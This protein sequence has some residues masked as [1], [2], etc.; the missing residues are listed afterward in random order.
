MHNKNSKGPST[1]PRGTPHVI[2][3]TSED[4]TFKKDILFCIT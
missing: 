2:S 1:D 4:S 3:L